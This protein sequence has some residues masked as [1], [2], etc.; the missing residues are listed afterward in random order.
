MNVL[1]NLNNIFKWGGLV[2]INETVLSGTPTM[3]WPYW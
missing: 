2:N 1:L 3:F